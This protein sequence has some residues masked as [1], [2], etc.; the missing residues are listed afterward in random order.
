MPLDFASPY[1]VC[2]FSFAWQ[3]PGFAS[4]VTL[5]ATSSWQGRPR[6]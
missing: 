1:P 6:R 4:F 3:A 5:Y 2:E